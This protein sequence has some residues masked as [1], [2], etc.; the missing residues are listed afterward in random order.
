MAYQS[1]IAKTPFWK[2]KQIDDRRKRK[3]KSLLKKKKKENIK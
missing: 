3:K 1:Y 2:A